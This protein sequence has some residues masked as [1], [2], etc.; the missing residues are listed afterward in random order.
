MNPCFYLQYVMQ[1][2]ETPIE[3]AIEI[4]QSIT[5]PDGKSRCHD[6]ETCCMKNDGVYGCCRLSADAVCCKDPAHCCLPTEG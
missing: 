6:G 2:V 5:C 3:D 1:Y 4:I